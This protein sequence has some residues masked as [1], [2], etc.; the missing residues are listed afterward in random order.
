MQKTYRI[1]GL[2]LAVFCCMTLV[3]GAAGARVAPG[4][5]P[6]PKLAGE[7]SPGPWSGHGNYTVNQTG[8]ERGAVQGNL[9]SHPAR[10]HGPPPGN[11]TE[12]NGTII[13]PWNGGGDGTG[14]M[15]GFHG[16]FT[17]PPPEHEN[18]TFTLNITGVNVT[19]PP[20]WAD[21]G[22]MQVNSTGHENNVTEVMELALQQGNQDDTVEALLAWLRSFTHTRT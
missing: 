19:G 7:Y 5:G 11:M 12:L 17:S 21:H 22:G 3:I 10:L 13:D 18:R 15:T 6:D 1:F 4:Q 2:A 8:P 9:T 20:P 14:N 16:N